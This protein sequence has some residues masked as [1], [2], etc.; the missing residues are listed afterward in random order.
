MERK[1]RSKGNKTRI[2]L[3]PTRRLRGLHARS[4]PRHSNLTQS[5]TQAQ[6]SAWGATEPI[7]ASP[8][9]LLEIL[10]IQ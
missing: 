4:C 8:D 10:T 3:F 7:A 5:N 9:F 2:R 1:E 6:R